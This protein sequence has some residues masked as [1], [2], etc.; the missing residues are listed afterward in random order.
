MAEQLTTK[1]SFIQNDLERELKANKEELRV[2]RRLVQEKERMTA[3]VQRVLEA[4]LV[5]Q[6]EISQRI[7]KKYESMKQ[8]NEEQLL[9]FTADNRSRVSN[10]RKELRQVQSKADNHH[11]QNTHFKKQI[12]VLNHQLNIL[13][14][15]LFCFFLICL[16]PVVKEMM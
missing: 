15:S 16:L 4:E 14:V 8:L 6:K 3:E 5:S 9:S 11:F 7:V 2:S 12:D 13:K 10:L 1:S